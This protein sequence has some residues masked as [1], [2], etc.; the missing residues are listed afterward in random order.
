MLS[1]FRQLFMSNLALAVSTV[2]LFTAIVDRVYSSQKSTEKNAMNILTRSSLF[3]IR[4]PFLA[5]NKIRW[6]KPYSVAVD[7]HDI[8]RPSCKLIQWS[9]APDHAQDLTNH[10]QQMSYALPWTQ[11][12]VVLNT[13]AM[14]RPTPSMADVQAAE[15]TNIIVARLIRQ[16]TAAMID[17]FTVDVDFRILYEAGIPPLGFENC[18]PAFPAPPG[19]HEEPPYV[20]KMSQS[21]GFRAKAPPV[22]DYMLKTFKNFAESSSDGV[23]VQ[24]ERGASRFSDTYNP[25]TYHQGLQRYINEHIEKVRSG[26]SLAQDSNDLP[27]AP[28]YFDY[29]AF[30]DAYKHEVTK[31]N[32]QLYPNEYVAWFEQHPEEATKFWKQ[33]HAAPLYW[34][35]NPEEYARYFP[36]SNFSDSTAESPQSQS[37]QPSAVSAPFECHNC[38]EPFCEHFDWTIP[39]EYLAAEGAHCTAT[40]SHEED[41]AGWCEQPCTVDQL[42]ATFAAPQPRRLTPTLNCEAYAYTQLYGQAAYNSEQD[43]Y[44]TIAKGPSPRTHYEAARLLALFWS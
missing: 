44:V 26:A 2:K 32:I 33:E 41:A 3:V 15:E 6:P 17:Y 24:C 34:M 42:V 21:G 20:P 13:K 4:S 40:D 9:G 22:N 38:G 23:S 10:E 11:E 16:T 39:E 29:H 7:K 31:H 36:S 43:P 19:P 35:Q 1:P 28:N 12:P 25:S 8:R 5:A 18:M 37:T 27:E 30:N 14:I